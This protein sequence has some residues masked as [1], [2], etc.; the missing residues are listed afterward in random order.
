MACVS[1]VTSDNFSFLFS[2][3]TLGFL[4]RCFLFLF[5]FL[6]SVS[7][8]YGRGISKSI[9]YSYEEEAFKEDVVVLADDYKL[10]VVGRCLTDR[11]V[12]FPSLRN[13]MAELWHPIGGR[14]ITN[15]GE[16]WYLFH[17]FMR[18]I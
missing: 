18:L 4:V 3:L 10:V 8:C 17:F 2:K 6:L 7:A 14:A 12:H 13:T 16:K 9:P 11:S 1:S 5:F 15:L